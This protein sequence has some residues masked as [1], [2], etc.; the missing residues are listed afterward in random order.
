MYW[1]AVWKPYPESPNPLIYIFRQFVKQPVIDSS[2]IDG[3]SGN[4]EEQAK[5]SLAFHVSRRNVNVEKKNRK[6]NER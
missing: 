5:T 4:V 1:L 3:L 6:G 2:G